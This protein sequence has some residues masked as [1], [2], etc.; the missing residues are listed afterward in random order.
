[1][2]NIVIIGASGHGS[3]I[4]DCIEK[5][6]KYNLLGFVDSFKKKGIKQN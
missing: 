4:L 1:M 5:E 6:N 2:K 3:V